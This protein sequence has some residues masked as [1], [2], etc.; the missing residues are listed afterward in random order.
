MYMKIK[1]AIDRSRPG[2]HQTTPWPALSDEQQCEMDQAV[3][4]LREAADQGHMRAQG[5]CGNLY[6]LGRGVAQDDRLA[7]LYYEKAAQQGHGSVC[8]ACQSNLAACYVQ[9]RGC[10][11]SH[12]RAAVWLKRA[13]SAG[14]MNAQFMLAHLHELG[15]GVAKDYLEARRLYTHLRKDSH[16]PPN[17]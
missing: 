12:E 4:M 8:V 16:R 2:V 1:A 14:S 5:Y 9:G 10:E 17:S 11:Q 15:F 7:F 13:A 3:A 6:C